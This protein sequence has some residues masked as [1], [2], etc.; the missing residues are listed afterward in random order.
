MA[1][2]FISHSSRD[3]AQAERLHQWL[4]DQGSTETFLDIDKHAGLMPGDDWERRLY[5]EIAAAEAVILIL[6]KNWFESKWC[7]GRIHSGARARQGDIPHRRDP[8]GEAFVSPTSSISTWSRTAEGGLE[9]LGSELT[10]LALNARG[11]F[12]WEKS[13]SP[14]P[15]LLAFGEA[16]AAIYFGRDDDIRRLIERPQC[17]RAQGGVSG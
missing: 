14:F 1:R 8:D 15:G 16:D 10:R 13:R 9:R 12:P 3:G 11:T 2:V 17:R 5:R 7:F 4:R 6:T